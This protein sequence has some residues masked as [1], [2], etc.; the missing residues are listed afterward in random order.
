MNPARIDLVSLKL[1]QAVVRTGSITRGAEQCS[2]ALGAASTRL[3]ELESR[4]GT[5]LLERHARGVR[6]TEAGQLVIDRARAIESEID[7]META[8]EDLRQGATGH[9]RIVANVTALST[10]LPRDLALFLRDHPGIRLDLSEETS[11]VAQRLLLDGLVD[12]AVMVGLQLHPELE[13]RPYMDDEL[14][15]LQAARD[16]E[17]RP[18]RAHDLLQEDLLLLQEGGH[19][20]DWLTDLARQRGERLRLRG[21]A[22]GFEALAQLVAAGLGLSV[23]PKSVAQRYSG[24]LDLQMRPIV[25][26]ETHRPLVIARRRGEEDPLVSQIWQGL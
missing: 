10:R 18:I 26:A 13:S 19:V 11:R 4:L 23:V 12:V 24:L 15:A 21:Q 5:Q 8:L 2:L 20:S 3:R 7:R 6:P 22:K 14:V 17:P 1:L 9:L 25:G 16:P